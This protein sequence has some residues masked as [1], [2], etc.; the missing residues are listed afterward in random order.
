MTDI[1]DNGKPNLL[2]GLSIVPNG[3]VSTIPSVSMA[4]LKP[5]RAMLYILSGARTWTCMTSSTMRLSARHRRPRM[6]QLEAPFGA[7]LT[8][9]PAES[10]SVG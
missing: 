9:G 8:P 10:L 7:G 3:L 2:A 4:L 6:E 1:R 5:F